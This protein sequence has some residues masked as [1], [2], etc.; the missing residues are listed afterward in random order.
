MPRGQGRPGAAGRDNAVARGWPRHPGGPQASVPCRRPPRRVPQGRLRSAARLPGAGPAALPPCAGGLPGKG[1][2]AVLGQR[3]RALLTLPLV[4]F[5]LGVKWRGSEALVS[6]QKA[7]ES[8]AG[9]GAGLCALRERW[10]SSWRRGALQQR[11]KSYGSGIKV[12]CSGSQQL[13]D[14]AVS[15]TKFALPA[16]SDEHHSYKW[17][18]C[19]MQKF[20]FLLRLVCNLQPIGNT[21]VCS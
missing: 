6:V 13:Q 5:L 7:G 21:S 18:L 10:Q 4:P 12:V 19:E 14:L 17:N 11:G 2:A 8:P 16:C 3:E 15:L 20:F 9:R 1:C